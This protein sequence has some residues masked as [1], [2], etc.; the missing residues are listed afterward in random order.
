MFGEDDLVRV[1]HDRSELI[2]NIIVSCFAILLARLWYLQIYNGKKFFNYSLENR[3]RKDVVRAPRGMIFSRNN[4][5]LTHNVPRFDAIITPQYFDFAEETIPDLAKVLEMSPETIKKTL[6]RYQG[7]AKYVP[8]V[9]KKNISRRE[10]AILETESNKFPGVSV[11]T[12]ISREYTDKDA[13]AHLLGYISEISQEKLPKYRDR[14]KYDYKQGDFIGQSGI[15][16]QYDLDIRGDDGFQFMEVDA[17]GRARRHVATGDLYTGIDNKIAA[18]GKNLRL[19][20]DRDVQ[21]AAYHALDGKDG[22]AVA[23]DIETGEV[24]A[25]VSRPGFDPANFSTGLTS[26]YWGELVMDEKHPLRDRVIQEHYSPGSTFKTLTAIAALEEGVIDEN[27]KVNCTGKYHLGARPFH[28]WKKEGHGS[29]DVYRSIKESCDVFYYTIGSKIDIDVIYKYATL[30]GMGQRLGI[31][32][33]R[34]TSGLI[35]NK[36][37]KMKRMKQEWQKGET[38][39]CV[40]GQ[41]FVNV[42]PLQLASFYATIANEGKLHR[43]HVVKEVFSNTGEVLKRYNT[44]TIHQF[45]LKKKTVDIIKQALYDVVNTPGGTATSLKGSGLQMAGKTGTAQVMSFSADKIFNKCENQEYKY[46]HHGLF[47]GYAPAT[48]PKIAI[49]VVVEHGCHGSSAA[50]PV[51]KAMVASYLNKYYPTYQ[52]KLVAQDKMN[53]VQIMDDNRNNP[54]TM[55]IEKGEAIY[56]NEEGTQIKSFYLDKGLTNTSTS[57]E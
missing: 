43:P 52:K 49:A 36:D 53:F 28:C 41:S 7:Q 45:K 35:P 55:G 11:E 27:F 23:I 44:E 12:F 19:T 10:V 29:V 57:G 46:R 32:L 5:L 13:G 16:Q 20:I 54:E 6:K 3:L 26:N 8:I 24:L 47:A 37:W 2:L 42:T 14:D 50:G 34:E 30:F 17:R 9:I 18:P 1:H 22:A 15:E 48:N 21:L 56:Y 31:V 4:V 40:I 25:M 39:S 51:A 33:P 38:L